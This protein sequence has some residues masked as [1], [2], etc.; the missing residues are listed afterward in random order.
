MLTAIAS[1]AQGDFPA[2]SNL[3]DRTTALNC[4]CLIFQKQGNQNFLRCELSANNGEEKYLYHKEP[5]GKPGLFLSW[6]IP[7]QGEGSVRMF[8]QLVKKEERNEEEN[9][10]IED[11]W[12]K[13][14]A[15]FSRLEEGKIISK[16]KLL[17][18]EALLG[19]LDNDS[20]TLLLNLCSSFAS[21]FESVKKEVQSKL[22][23]YEFG[24]EKGT[25][26]NKLLV[27]IALENEKGDIEYPGDIQ[28][29]VTLFTRAVSG[30]VSA[31]GDL[32]CTV[33][34]SHSAGEL[35]IP[36]P[37]E[38]LTQDQLVYVP[39]GLAEK[40]KY[41]LAL[42]QTCSDNLR[43]GQAFVNVHLS[44]KI[45][46]SRLF[47]W[48]LPA[49]ADPERGI[50]YLIGLNGEAKPLYLS[51]LR[52]LCAGLEIAAE[53]SQTIESDREIEY[54]LTYTS[55][56]CYKDA[57]GHTRIA[58]VAEGIN[59]SRLRA[60][61]DAS[62]II[63]KKFP[64]FL[65]T[66]K[67]MFSFPL[68]SDF[69]QSE[70]GESLLV[71]I[72]EALFSG[73]IVDQSFTFARIAEK[74]R[75]KGLTRVIK[76]GS[77]PAGKLMHS[78]VNSAF[79]ALIITE[80]LAQTGVLEIDGGTIMPLTESSRDKSIESLQKF[81]N[82][83]K[84]LSL[85]DTL[86]STFMVGVA[87]GI[88]LEVQMKQ[89]NSYPYWKHLNRLEL[90]LDRVKRFYPEVRAKLMNY[91]DGAA[92]DRIKELETLIAYIGTNLEFAEEKDSRKANSDF[93][94]L[95]FSIG[96]SEGYLLYH[97]IGV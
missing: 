65:M 85:N 62:Q 36:Y 30:K 6:T 96:L 80:Y 15:W 27:T 3:V 94:D 38:F 86:R 63:Q 57:Q 77:T 58:G 11:F 21:S 91:R 14:F 73:S 12:E 71:G 46:K 18:D 7:S 51:Q 35:S 93:I 50:R 64:Y 25:R 90:G 47:F 43:A 87:V 44:Y 29:F 66:P 75:S 1:L 37:L 89:F 88:L 92:K 45:L 22:V 53:Q 9:R 31:R 61:S 83:H 32:F 56:F 60:L 76:K 48:L 42:C 68:L 79:D 23:E 81:I 97:G 16:N 95:A 69:F 26:N 34:N 20:K 17:N 67:V 2:L 13:K 33:C 10:M 4:L 52:D 59:P 84:S 82:S 70:R 72:M 54:W 19:T 41:A 28:S 78:F 40:K 49:F 5:S 55:V 39:D 74:V 24:K 8:Q